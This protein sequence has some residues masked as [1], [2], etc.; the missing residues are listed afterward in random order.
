MQKKSV[1]RTE[2]RPEPRVSP[3]V[4]TPFNVYG[5]ISQESKLVKRFLQDLKEMQVFG[6]T[7][8][9]HR[10]FGFTFFTLFALFTF[11]DVR[12][13]SILELFELSAL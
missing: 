3:E 10:G 11:C 8:R 5:N 6:A 1:F 4:S 13:I 12:V 9:E 2:E 7:L